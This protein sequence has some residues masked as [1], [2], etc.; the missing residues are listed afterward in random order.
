M[1][2]PIELLLNLSQFL[3]IRD[4]LRLR[5]VCKEWR[6]FMDE[7]C[8]EELVLFLHIHPTLELWSYNSKAIEFRNLVFLRSYRCLSDEI[9]FKYAFRNVKKL[10]LCIWQQ[11]DA[12]YRLGK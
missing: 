11:E 7:F 10:F 9:G 5:C 1:R 6:S 3:G 4:R 8:L 2:I 12:A